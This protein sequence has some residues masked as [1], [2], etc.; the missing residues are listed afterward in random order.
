V[1]L[2]VALTLALFVWVEGCAS[3]LIA[4]DDAFDESARTP[5]QSYDPELGWVS[6][7]SLAVRD[8]F[9]PGK[10]LHTDGRGFRVRNELSDAATPG[11]IRVLCSGDSFTFG[12]GVGDDSSWCQRLTELD[13]R[14]ESVNLGLPGYG[15]DQS[16]L[17]YRRDAG[18]VHHDLHLFAFIGA[19]LDRAA[20]REHNGYA[21]PLLQLNGSA[22]EVTQ[23][24]VPRALPYVRRAAAQL[25]K[26]LQSV[27]LLRRVLYKLDLRWFPPA[28]D[29]E[30][31]QPLLAR[32]FGE[33]VRLSEERGS[34]PVF[35]YLPVAGEREKDGAWRPWVKDAMRSAGHAF[36]D[37]TDGL[38]A[39]PAEQLEAYF[40]PE[41]EP[42]GGHY[43]ELGNRW[44]AREIRRAL[45]DLPA[46]AARL[47]SR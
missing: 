14:L 44:A 33:V 13:P 26:H 12:E 10:D 11:R 28:P 30:S 25:A 16:L 41:C 23:V 43:S 22:L 21:K 27:E 7:P 9:G 1:A 32:V 34:V 24:P 17:R 29:R 47:D 15:V 4:V 42:A 31:Q 6:L 2:F 3:S 40:I 38:R 46:A 5:L 19:D 36:I 39:L 45:L 18:A 8:A 20:R 35:V 37:L